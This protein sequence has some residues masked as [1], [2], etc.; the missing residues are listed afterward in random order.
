MLGVWSVHGEGRA[1]CAHAPILSRVLEENLSPLR[2][3]DDAGNVT[4]TYP[5]NPSGSPHGIAALCSP[6]GRHLAVMV[7]TCFV[8][9]SSN[10]PEPHPERAFLKWQW[11]YLPHDGKVEGPSVWLRFFQN[12]RLWCGEQSQA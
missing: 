3:A 1:H 11:P 5:N 7:Q 4:M 9:V 12:A 6:D 10:M 2:F 8:S